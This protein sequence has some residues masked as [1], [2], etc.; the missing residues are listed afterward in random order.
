MA[1]TA[2]GRIRFRM[3]GAWAANTA[4]EVMD[5]VRNTA[6]TIAYMAKKAVP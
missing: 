1:Y 5:V 2:I 3:R 4:Y 6:G